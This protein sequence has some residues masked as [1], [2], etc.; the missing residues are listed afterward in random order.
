[1]ADMTEQKVGIWYYASDNTSDTQPNDKVKLL[2]KWE[3]G[4]TSQ[5]KHKRTSYTAILVHICTGNVLNFSKH[6][7]RQL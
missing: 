5:I 3:V 4:A 1:M 7:Q 2:E 6:L